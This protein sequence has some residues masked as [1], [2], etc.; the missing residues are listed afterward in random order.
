M[1]VAYRGHDTSSVTGPI[2]RSITKVD[3]EESDEPKTGNAAGKMAHTPEGADD[4]PDVEPM[5]PRE[6][7]N[8]NPD[9]GSVSKADNEADGA[10]I[11]G[12]RLH[13]LRKPAVSTL[14]GKEV[15]GISEPWSPQ[16]TC[17]AA[18]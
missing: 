5:S 14:E 7:P 15:G 18:R 13:S 4:S 16:R 11:I 9:N 8:G 1:E 17:Q 6:S 12:T 3:I 10:S 2:T